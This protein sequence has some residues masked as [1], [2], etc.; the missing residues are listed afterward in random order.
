MSTVEQTPSSSGVQQLIDRLH[1]E[2]LTKGQ[3]Q[4]E[5]LIAEARKQAASTLDK[6][7]HEADTLIAT[8]VSEAERTRIA[9]EEAVRLAGRD[10]ILRLNEELR[11]DFDR[12][13]RGLVGQTLKDNTFLKELILAVARESMPADS[14]SPRNVQLLLDPQQI[15]ALEKDGGDDPLDEFCRGMSGEALRDGLTFE[16]ADSEVPGIRVQLT[17]DDLEIDLSADTITHL[18]IKHLSPRFRAI[19]NHM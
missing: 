4:A 17:E 16:I 2:G 10:T 12:K 19:V 1:Q 9:G 18:L 11:A 14:T 6:A 15:E 13:I 5:Q 3:E 7:R 8:A